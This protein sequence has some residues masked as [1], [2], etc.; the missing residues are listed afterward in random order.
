MLRVHCTGMHCVWNRNVR[1]TSNVSGDKRL[2]PYAN[3]LRYPKLQCDMYVDILVGKCVSLDGNKYTAFYGTIFGWCYADP[4]KLRNEVHYTLRGL[5]ERIGVPSVLIPDNAGELTGGNFRKIA[6]RY[7]STI[8]PIEAYTPNQNIAE[9]LIREVKRSYRRI[10]HSTNTPECCWDR[11]IRHTT[12][13]RSHTAFGSPQ[14][15][16]KTPTH[17]LTGQSPDI[18]FM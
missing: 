1:D 12:I 10:M 9:G 8:H 4:I 7:G 5:F 14:L 2:S 16:G 15:Q 18:S 13:V 17:L 6:L 11:C 3:L